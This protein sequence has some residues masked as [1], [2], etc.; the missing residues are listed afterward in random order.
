MVD[1]WD[2][3]N[4]ETALAFLSRCQTFDGAFA[5][6]PLEESHGGSTYCAVAAYSLAGRGDD[7]KNRTNLER[8]LLSRQQHDSGF[9][10][11]P[12]KPVDTCYS[13]WCGGALSVSP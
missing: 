13:F 7:I 1:A 12:E 11:R 6:Q 5:Q 9:N 3:I 8:W 2:S 10:G 4:L